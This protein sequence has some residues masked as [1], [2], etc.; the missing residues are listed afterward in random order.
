MLA[1]FSDLSHLEFETALTA[2]LEGGGF[3]GYISST[4]LSVANTVCETGTVTPD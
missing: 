4:V 2:M 1:F 3:F